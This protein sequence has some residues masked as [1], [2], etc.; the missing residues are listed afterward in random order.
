ML[1]PHCYFILFCSVPFQ[2]V[3]FDATPLDNFLFCSVLFYSV[4]SGVPFS[5]SM[6][7]SSCFYSIMVSAWLCH[8]SLS[9]RDHVV[10]CYV[11][12]KILVC[13]S[14]SCQLVSFHFMSRHLIF[15]FIFIL[16]HVTSCRFVSPPFK[17]F[18]SI[19][20]HRLLYT[21]LC[22]FVAFRCDLLAFFCG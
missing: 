3:L 7:V 5:I 6:F 11:I 18:R 12:S 17:S 14:M 15:I 16:F 9:C 2:S 20:Y 21:S 10:L 4:P 19:S 13:H 8:M 22:S 1:S